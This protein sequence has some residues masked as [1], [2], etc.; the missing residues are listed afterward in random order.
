MTQ[1]AWA[2]YLSSAVEGGLGV[3]K[4]YR[5]LFDALE[6]KTADLPAAAELVAAIGQV[7]DADPL[8]IPALRAMKRAEPPPI[9]VSYGILDGMLTQFARNTQRKRRAPQPTICAQVPAFPWLF[10]AQ[11]SFPGDDDLRNQCVELVRQSFGYLEIRIS[12][13]FEV[14]HD[15]RLLVAGDPP[16]LVIEESADA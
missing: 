4:P 12:N 10:D 15:G 14:G 9:N 5:D 2:E 8:R 3:E 11:A 13:Y 7:D 16:V 6:A 1:P